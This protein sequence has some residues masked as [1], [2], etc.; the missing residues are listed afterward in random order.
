MQM[1]AGSVGCKRKRESEAL[2]PLSVAG[3]CCVPGVRVCGLCVVSVHVG[4]FA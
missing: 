2:G 4:W 1:A 3:G